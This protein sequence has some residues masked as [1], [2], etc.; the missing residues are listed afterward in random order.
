MSYAPDCV[1]RPQTLAR[2]EWQQTIK[3]GNTRVFQEV[4]GG[5]VGLGDS[6][7]GSHSASAGVRRKAVSVSLANAFR[8]AAVLA[9]VLRTAEV[10]L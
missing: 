9:S 3:V 5:E 1:P 4:G 10:V 6:V 8:K 7:V 2:R